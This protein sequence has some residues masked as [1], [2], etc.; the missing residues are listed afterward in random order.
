[1][2]EIAGTRS[3][4]NGSYLNI[5]RKCLS[6]VNVIVIISIVVVDT[7]IHNILDCLAQSSIT[8]N[9]EYYEIQ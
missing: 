2:V 1:M 9:L 4:L 5:K 6:S 3:K 8:V 7:N